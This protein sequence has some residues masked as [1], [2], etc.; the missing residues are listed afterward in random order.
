MEQ[1]VRQSKEVTKSVQDIGATINSTNE[2][3]MSISTFTQA[4]TSI[5]NQTN[6]LSL[7]A[8]IEAARAG[9]AGR[10]FAVVAT[11]ISQLA[12]QSRS[13]VD[14]IS[15]IVNK[16]LD[17]AGLSVKVLEKL[18]ESFS[19]QS[20]LLDSTKDDME[21]MST[22]VGNVRNTSGS[23]TE[24]VV[25]L[26]QAKNRLLGIITDLSAISEENAA[27]SQETSASMEELHTTFEL[28]NN[29]AANLQK[30]AMELSETI[31]Y[32]KC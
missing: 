29:S 21:I 13:S 2:A 3:A 30:I 28:I 23:I 5:A 20:V 27:S 7:N 17:E 16:L 11:E 12:E 26:S 6:L 24:R 14:E 10:G 8:S 18:N 22:N 9:E 19:Q 32:F 4:I 25:S 1:L 31:E 15:A